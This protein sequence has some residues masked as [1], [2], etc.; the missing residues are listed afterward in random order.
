MPKSK[1]PA[2]CLVMAVGFACLSAQAALVRGVITSVL[3]GDTLIVRIENDEKPVRLAGVDAP[4]PD[5]TFGPEAKNELQKKVLNREVLVL[6]EE[7]EQKEDL[8]LAQVA[9]DNTDI[10]LYLIEKGMAWSSTSSVGT[11]SAD[12]Q[13]AYFEAEAIAKNNEHGLWGYISPIAPW[14]WRKMKRDEERTKEEELQAKLESVSRSR[15]ELTEKIK[16]MQKDAA[17]KEGND[18]KE[19]DVTRKRTLWEHLVDITQP[20]CRLIVYMFI[21]KF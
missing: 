11:V 20:L 21:G 19:L 18:G 1:F 14:T 6:T 5:Q 13:E 16:D 10:G 15:R 7:N 12:W 2:V 9:V 4:E 17:Q 8:T 3:D